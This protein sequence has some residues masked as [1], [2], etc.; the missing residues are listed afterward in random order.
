ELLDVVLVDAGEH[1]GEPSLRIDVVEPRGLDQ[2]VHHG[3]TFTAAVGASEQPRLAPE[4][5]TAQ[6]PLG[7]IVGEADA[8]VPNETRER[9]PALEHVVHGLAHIAVARELATLRPHPGLELGDQWRDALAT[10]RNTLLNGAAVDLALNVEDSVNALDCL[11]RERRQRG[12]RPARLGG[13]VGKL[14]ELASTVRPTAR[15]R[16]RAG[17]TIYGIEPD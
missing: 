17:A 14:E 12:Q 5:N 4:R 16:D 8:A 7:G 2:G 9:V 15:L 3:G 13:H 6:R 10:D 11:D 1:V